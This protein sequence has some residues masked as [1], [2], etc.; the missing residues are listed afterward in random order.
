MKLKVE[1]I[2][3]IFI[4]LSKRAPIEEWD[5]A[6][7]TCLFQDSRPIQKYSTSFFNNKGL[8]LKGFL[9]LFYK[10]RKSYRRAQV[11]YAPLKPLASAFPN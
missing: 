10:P 2:V 7:N 1:L 4:E 5:L 6:I 8:L 11:Q 9:I 3:F